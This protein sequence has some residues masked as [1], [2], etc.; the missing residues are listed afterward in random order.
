MGFSNGG[1][2]TLQMAIRH[3]EKVNKIVPISA[4]YRRD[5]LLNG[6]FEGFENVHLGMMPQPLKDA[7]L[8]VNP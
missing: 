8:E 6:F 5:G 2:T 3:P 7:F 1:T 4:A